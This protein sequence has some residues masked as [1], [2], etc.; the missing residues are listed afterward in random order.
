VKT[1]GIRE[2]VPAARPIDA[3]DRKI[4][5][6]LVTDA[7]QSYAAL[8][9]AVALSAP[10]VHERVKRL[11]AAG[12]IR[13]TAALIDGKAIGRP[14]LVFIHVATQ[15]WGHSEALDQLAALPEFEEV[16]SVTGDTSIILKVRLADSE[17]L[18][19]LLRQLHALESVLSTKTFVALSTYL[20]RPTQAET[21]EHWADPPLPKE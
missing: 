8:G 13:S 17:A 12:V 10:A 20:E 9:A 19:H 1:D 5:G 16:H 3:A 6:A 21:T 2:K 14:L 11:K 4:L 15:N 7:S 18:E